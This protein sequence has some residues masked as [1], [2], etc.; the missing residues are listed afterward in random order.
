MSRIEVA[1]RACGT[2]RCRLVM[3]MMVMIVMM[4]VL[5]LLVE[6]VMGV[7]VAGDGLEEPPRM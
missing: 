6:L 1:T 2:E 4:M 3:M 5:V 7:V